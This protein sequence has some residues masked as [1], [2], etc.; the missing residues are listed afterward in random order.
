MI[1]VCH[2]IV[3]EGYRETYQHLLLCDCNIILV[4]KSLAKMTKLYF[5]GLKP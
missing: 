1:A 5:S 2:L 4:L 3:N